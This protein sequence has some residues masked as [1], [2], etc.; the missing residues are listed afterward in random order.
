MTLP[1][2]ERLET[3]G[4]TRARFGG[5]GFFLTK[6]AERGYPVPPFRILESARLRTGGVV[7]AEIEALLADLRAEAIEQ[8][9]VT[10]ASVAFAVRSSAPV[11]MPGMMD[12]LLG[13]GLSPGQISQLAAR[14]GSA[15]AAWDMLCT[16]ARSLCVHTAGMDENEIGMIAD[17][18]PD[19]Y[20]HLVT[21]YE[22]RTGGAFPETPEVQ[23]LHAVHAVAKSWHNG[24]AQDYRRVHRISETACPAVVI[25]VMAF[26]T[27]NGA[28]GSGVV[29]S[30]DP[31]TG[32]RGLHGEYL[33]ASTGESLVSGTTT[34]IDATKLAVE[35][36][37][38]Y[39]ELVERVDELFRWTTQMV[40]VEFVVEGGRLWLVQLRPAVCTDEVRNS[41]TVDSWRDGLIDRT[42]ALRRL[43]L[44]ALFA[45]TPARAADGSAR[46][47]A[48]GLAASAGVATGRLVSHPD[49]AVAQA[50]E[51]TVLFRQKTEPE[52]FLGMVHS[53]AV[54]TLEG[55]AGSHAA[56]VARE[57]GRPAVVGASFE[58]PAWLQQADGAVV[59]VCGTTG[60]V[61]LGAVTEE[62][63]AELVWPADLIGAPSDTH[64]VESL[65]DVVAAE[66]DAV[67]VDGLDALERTPPRGLAVTADPRV[68]TLIGRSRRVAYIASTSA[69]EPWRVALPDVPVA[70]IV[71]ASAVQ[72]SYVQAALAI[73]EA[74]AV[75]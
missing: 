45:Q 32:E 8:M 16:A 31:L 74:A 4:V 7:L 66:P 72:R 26:G 2:V 54:V 17:P 46:L 14:L 5:K 37:D 73:R 27:A 51:P 69:R 36:Q 25:Q 22:R 20:E 56:V 30:H 57:L 38:S 18:G 33:P 39:S 64:I 19:A 23:V 61:W 3:A 10:A 68:A 71:V 28:S 6:L 21:A 1:V 63:A 62:D 24:R 42:E 60:R 35:D 70:Y 53:V 49:A 75:D 34:P 40:E 47:L 58:D 12:T 9:G 44:D 13:I 52:D 11:S 15:H 48:T 55:G 59:T 67:M 29:F 65:D 41:V 50:D 43:N